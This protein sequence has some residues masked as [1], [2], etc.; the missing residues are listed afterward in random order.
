M[1]PELYEELEHSYNICCWINI[2]ELDGSLAINCVKRRKPY[3]GIVLTEY[4]RT[5]LTKHIVA[6]AHHVE[7]H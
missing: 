3:I 4:H 7:S 2:T 1:P 5:E 6:K